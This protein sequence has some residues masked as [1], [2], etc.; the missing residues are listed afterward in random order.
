MRA[1]VCTPDGRIAPGATIIQ[2]VL[3]G[4]VALDMSV[5]VIEKGPGSL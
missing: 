5:R 1:L 2:R 3:M 4:P